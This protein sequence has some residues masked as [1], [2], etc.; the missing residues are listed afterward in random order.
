[1]GKANTAEKNWPGASTSVPLLNVVIIKDDGRYMAKCP[2]LDLITEMDS[3]ETALEAMVEMV[4]EYAA[5][6]KSHE[7][8]YSKSPNRAHHK[9]YVDRIV[10]C[11]DQWEVM[12]LI[13]VRY[14]RLHV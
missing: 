6:Y 8:K 1:M 9:P 13:G 3:K 11:K 4:A 14:G 12:E 5:D 10:A 2:E 7:E